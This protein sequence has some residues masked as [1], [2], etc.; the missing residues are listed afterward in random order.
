MCQAKGGIL[1]TDVKG[2]LT[3]LARDIRWIFV[4]L[5]K[6]E[7]HKKEKCNMW[8]NMV[9]TKYTNAKYKKTQKTSKPTV[10]SKE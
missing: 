1:T 3:V 10:Y 5:D 7:A 9:L 4:Y 6:T 2:T 8:K